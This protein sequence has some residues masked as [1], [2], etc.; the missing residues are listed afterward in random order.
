MKSSIGNPRPAPPDN[1][2]ERAKPMIW[3]IEQVADFKQ[4]RDKHIRWNQLV[5]LNLRKENPQLSHLTENSSGG[6]DYYRIF[7]DTIPH[8]RQG[9][10]ACYYHLE[11]VENLERKIGEIALEHLPKLSMPK[12]STIAGGDTNRLDAEYH[13]FLFGLRRTLDYFANSAAA[14]FRVSTWGITNLEK[15]IAGKDPA[16]VRDRISGRIRKAKPELTSVIGDGTGRKTPR[17]KA[18]HR[19]FVSAG[20]INMMRVGDNYSVVICGGGEGLN[21]GAKLKAKEIPVD[22]S[23]QRVV[24]MS[25]APAL[26]NQLQVAERLIMGSYWDMGLL[27]SPKSGGRS[28]S[29]NLAA[30]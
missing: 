16:P 20:V 10:T 8:V 7:S 2:L 5:F 30:I 1:A 15:A 12:N 22:G 3:L 11:N 18:A 4:P 19:E 13:A 23:G 21:F 28:V 6:R 24:V 29:E 26:A 9:L 14:Y 27:T 17:D 25:L